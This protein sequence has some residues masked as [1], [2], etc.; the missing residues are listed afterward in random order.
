ML[1]RQSR[2]SSAAWSE[3]TSHRL[4]SA[5]ATASSASGQWSNRWQRERMVGRTPSAFVARSTSSTL[6]GG[7]SRVFSSALAAGSLRC[8]AP[9]MMVTRH[10]PSKGRRYA[11]RCT[12][13]TASMLMARWP[14]ISWTSRTRTSGCRPSSMWRHWS[15]SPQGGAAPRQFTAL[16]R[17]KATV[18]LPTWGGPTRR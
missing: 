13:R 17:A 4:I 3:G 7:S 16:A 10:W 12:S 15:H 5:W 9:S 6:G 1:P 2:A 14:A 11:W 18:P 8:S